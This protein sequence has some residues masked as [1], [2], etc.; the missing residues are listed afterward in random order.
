MLKKVPSFVLDMTKSPT[1]PRGYACGLVM[2][3]AALD[4]IFEHPRDRKS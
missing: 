4:D 2:P 3:A 1:Y